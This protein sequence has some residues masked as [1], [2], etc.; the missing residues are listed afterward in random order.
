LGVVRIDEPS[1]ADAP[2]VRV[3]QPSVPPGVPVST[4][5][6][7]LLEN[8]ITRNTLNDARGGFV[9]DFQVTFPIDCIIRPLARE[10]PTD[11]ATTSPVLQFERIIT[12]INEQ[13]IVIRSLTWLIGFA[14][15]ATPDSVSILLDTAETDGQ[16][17]HFRA[18]APFVSSGRVIGDAASPLSL[19]FSQFLPL[20]LLPGDRLIFRQTIG[21]AAALGSQVSRFQERSQLPFRPAGL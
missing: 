14:A 21:V 16:I 2:P 15:T 5:S 20:A 7:F 19:L 10:T 9:Q 4:L 6:R 18:E 3:V 11:S 12:G 8:G 13:V 1:D 17:E